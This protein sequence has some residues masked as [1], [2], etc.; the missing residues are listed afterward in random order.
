[1]KSLI[2]PK[3]DL[4]G[5]N[6]QVE[7]PSSKSLANR[8]LVLAALSRGSF[9]LRGDFE[10]EDVQF[11]IGALQVLGVR[12][13]RTND[14]VCFENDLKWMDDERELELF[15]GNSGTALRFLT[16]LALLRKGST[17]LTGV[18]RM[19]QRPI[20]DLINALQQLGA[21]IE[22]LELEGFPPLRVQ[23]LKEKKGGRVSIRGD[24]SSQF[25]SSILLVASAFEGE[26][27]MA[28]EGKLVSKPYVEMTIDLMRRWDISV[29]YSSEGFRVFPTQL[30]GMDFEV[31]GDASAATYW[32]ALEFLHDCVINVLNVQNVSKQGDTQFRRVLNMLK[33]TQG[34]FQI[35]M[36]DMPDAA[37][38]LMAVAPFHH[39]EVLIKNIGNLRVKESDRIEAMRVELMKCGVEVEAGGDWVRTHPLAP[40]LLERGRV[41][42]ETYDDHRVVMSMAVFGTMVGG[43]EILGAECVT[44]SYPRFWEHLKMMY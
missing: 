19:K 25:L 38:T 8:A 10:A 14:G 29:Q 42:I 39:S 28:L 1:M 36:N 44:K 5:K 35:D 41:S 43:L 34:P 31:E 33:T 22:Y 2:I 26:V 15:L 6:F 30:Y 20:G 23:G 18:D 3:L 9:Q 13:E 32:W 21:E 27:D 11:M 12:V 40:S 4:K 37:L 17:V 7:V 24:V 16:S